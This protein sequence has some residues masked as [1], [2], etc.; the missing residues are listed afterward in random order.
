MSI[1]ISV[2]TLDPSPFYRMFTSKPITM[3]MIISKKF[4]LAVLE[5]RISIVSSLLFFSLSLSFFNG[6]VS[7]FF[8]FNF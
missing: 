2:K 8:V 5:K 3:D 1:T 4:A 7:P 6:A